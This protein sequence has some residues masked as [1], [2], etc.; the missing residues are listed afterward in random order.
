MGS[1]FQ[2]E[3]NDP[4]DVRLVL[5]ATALLLAAIVAITFLQVTLRY[6]IGAPLSWGEELARY[7]FVWITF[8]GAAVA[9]ARGT[10][11]RVDAVVELAGTGFVRLT[12]HV[13]HAV[14]LTAIGI[15]VYSGVIV[16]WRYRAQ[17]FYSL[18][19]APLVVF[20]LAIP[21]AALLMAYFFVR[22]VRKRRV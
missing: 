8:A 4:G 6:L 10:H 5:N 18:K 19:E 13:R 14:E 1:S 7:I 11:I 21:V 15:L 20:P 9:Y 2:H 12:A 17:S 22:Y 3:P 16:A